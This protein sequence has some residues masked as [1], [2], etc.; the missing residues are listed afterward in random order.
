MWASR[1]GGGE[2]VQPGHAGGTHRRGWVGAVG[3]DRLQVGGV[4]VTVAEE[5]AGQVRL[6]VAVDRQSTAAD[7][8][9]PRRQ[10]DRRDRLADSAVLVGDG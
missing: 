3:D 4:L 9:E 8:G 5:P 10:V 6:G 7:A 1:G 2:C